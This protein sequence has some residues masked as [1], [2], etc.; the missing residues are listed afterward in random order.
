MINKEQ[1]TQ[2]DNGVYY[3]NRDIG[4][5]PMNDYTYWQNYENPTS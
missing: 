5:G 3:R 4:T 1:T 2:Q